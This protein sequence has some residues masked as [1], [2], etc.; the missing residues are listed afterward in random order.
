MFELSNEPFGQSSE[1]LS[2]LPASLTSNIRTTSP[3]LLTPITCRVT[4]MTTMTATMMTVPKARG[5]GNFI[6]ADQ[7]TPYV[8]DQTFCLKLSYALIFF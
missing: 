5:P 6:H 3:G 2:K 4:M 1:P 8:A 7:I